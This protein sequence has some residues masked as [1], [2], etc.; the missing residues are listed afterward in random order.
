MPASQ[1]NSDSKKLAMESG[2]IKA[3]ASLHGLTSS[4][5]LKDK[6]AAQRKTPI[7]QVRC[8]GADGNG[9][10]FY[11]ADSLARSGT[12]LDTTPVKES[13]QKMLSGFENLSRAHTILN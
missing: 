5:D 11:P 7:K 1:Y 9:S 2:P 8:L 3:I 13:T 10:P 12:M 4:T 6:S